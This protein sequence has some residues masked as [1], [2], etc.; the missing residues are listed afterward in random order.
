VREIAFVQPLRNLGSDFDI[1]ISAAGAPL[2]YENLVVAWLNAH[3]LSNPISFGVSAIWHSVRL[4]A[5]G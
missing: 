2:V 4:Q 5:A 3:M 1:G